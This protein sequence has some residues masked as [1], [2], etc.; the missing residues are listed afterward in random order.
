MRIE[1]EQG[2]E[3][4]NGEIGEICIKGATIMK[5]YWKRPEDT[6]AAIKDGWFHT[7]DIGLLDEHGFLVIKDR[8]KDIVIRGGENIACA[9]IEYALAEHPAVCEAAVFGLPDERLGEVVGAAVMTMPGAVLTEEELGA[10]LA[11]RLAQFKLPCFYRIQSEQLQRIASGK[12]AKKL[13]REEVI[14]SLKTTSPS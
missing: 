9:E 3:L 5:G 10:F 4:P 12:I 13:I 8:A 1:D 2:R 6:A 7:G 14:A 11:E